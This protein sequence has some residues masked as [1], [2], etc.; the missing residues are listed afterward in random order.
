MQ[1]VGT[2]L[3]QLS[4]T[5]MWL[6]LF[7]IYLFLHVLTDIKKNQITPAGMNSFLQLIRLTTLCKPIRKCTW[8]VLHVY[9]HTTDRIDKE[10]MKY[11]VNQNPWLKRA[12][13]EFTRDVQR[14]GCDNSGFRPWK[15]IILPF[16]WYS[17]TIMIYPPSPTNS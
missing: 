5:T 3:Q 1:Q 2:H 15:I 4:F 13:C 8:Y 16:L 14:I 10:I 9:A 17:I 7:R 6:H 12:F 11:S